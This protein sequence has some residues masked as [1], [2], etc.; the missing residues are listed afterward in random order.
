[1]GPARM[2]WSLQRKGPADEARHQERVR[3]AI[4]AHVGDIVA[5]PA[6]TG[7]DGRAV[8]RVPVYALKE[9]RFHFDDQRQPQVG[10][11][12]GGTAVGQVLARGS[13]AGA[14]APTPGG[15]SPGGR[16]GGAEV[17][18]AQVSVEDLADIVFED[19][20]LPD[21]APKRGGRLAETG[22][23]SGSV[24]SRGPMSALDRRRSLE[25]NLRRNARAGRPEVRDWT[26]DD[27]RFRSWRERPR[28]GTAAAV[29]AM[30]DVSG[31]MGE[32]KKYMARSFFF[33]MVRF[34]RTRYADVDMVFIA[35]HTEARE[36]DED[37]FF[38]LAESG[39]TRVSSA[40]ELA[41]DVMRSRYDPSA[42][43]VYT[44]HFSDGNCTLGRR[45]EMVS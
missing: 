19:L 1:M 35:H 13:L 34:L 9:Y 28:A 8:V 5:D 37:T 24:R 3:D 43:N 4:R 36:V 23:R 33:W 11:G 20:H 25:Q 39:G 42:W 45:A 27:L 31:S 21:L 15:C 26:E 41:L 2:D 32:F 30:R 14:G 17:I 16:D 18:E 38:R 44:C 12:P 7:G 29:V 40:Y 22:P 6:I 10:Q